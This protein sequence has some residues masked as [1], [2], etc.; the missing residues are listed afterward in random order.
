MKGNDSMEIDN[1]ELQNEE[2]EYQIKTLLKQK[3]ELIDYMK[4]L[5]FYSTYEIEMWYL[6]YAK[7]D[8]LDILNELELIQ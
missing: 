8:L 1:I 2:L 6:I 5:Y 4:H 7:C 3:K